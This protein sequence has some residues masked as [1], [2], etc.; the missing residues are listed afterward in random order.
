MSRG[1][2]PAALEETIQFRMTYEGEKELL[3]KLEAEER[4][5]Q[6]LKGTERAKPISPKNPNATPAEPDM[7]S[8][9]LAE[10][11]KRLAFLQSTI[12]CDFRVDMN[13]AFLGA[14]GEAKSSA[15][16]LK[17]AATSELPTPQV[18]VQ[19]QVKKRDSGVALGEEDEEKLAEKIA[20]AVRAK[21]QLEV[22]L[23]TEK[24]KAREAEKPIDEATVLGI[25][26]RHD[27]DPHSIEIVKRGLADP[28]L[29]EAIT[30]RLAQDE[31]WRV[32]LL[33]REPSS[34]PSQAAEK[35]LDGFFAAEDS[36]LSRANL[37]RFLFTPDLDYILDKEALELLEKEKA[38]PQSSADDQPESSLPDPQQEIPVPLPESANRGYDA[39]KTA[40]GDIQPQDAKYLHAHS[41]NTGAGKD[42]EQQLAEHD[43]QAEELG[44]QIE[45]QPGEASERFCRIRKKLVLLD[46]LMEQRVAYWARMSLASERQ[47]TEAMQV[48]IS[49]QREKTA[50]KKREDGNRKYRVNFNMLEKREQMS[51]LERME[52]RYKMFG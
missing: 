8:M 46:R 44:R 25:I 5:R 31:T 50:P 36:E 7:K 24:K 51:E 48:Q 13:K 18:R 43:A 32:L 11:R 6:R 20:R 35:M 15:K 4:E 41:G 10:L 52:R 27:K 16:R 37:L 17:T 28:Q 22:K 26:D 45:G 14:L 12:V 30:A 21:M 1:T 23:E 2:G 42:V 9:G 38:I 47:K 33:P 49:E 19:K 29:F 3:L 39:R 40:E 34:V